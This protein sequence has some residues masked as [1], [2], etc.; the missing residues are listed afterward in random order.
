MAGPARVMFI[1]LFGAVGFLVL[2]ACANVA[3][4]LL[5]R[6]AHR[7]REMAVRVA[8]GATRLRIVR[9][10]LLESVVLGVPRRRVRR[11]HC[12]CRCAN[13]RRGRAGSREALLDHLQGRLLGARLRVG[14]V[15][16]DRHSVRPGARAARLERQPQQRAQRGRTRQCR[17]AARALA[18]RHDGRRRV[19]AD[20]RAAGRRRTDGSQLP[21]ALQPRHRH[22]H[23]SADGHAPSA[24]GDQI[25]E[26]RRSARVLRSARAAAARDCGRR[27]DCGHDGRA[28]VSVGAANVRDRRPAAARTTSRGSS[29]LRGHDQP[30]VLRCRAR[31]AAPRPGLQRDGRASRQRDRDH[32]RAAG[33]AVFSLERIRSDGASD[34]H[35]AATPLRASRAEMWRTIVGISPSIRHNEARD[36]QPTAAMYLPHRQ[37]PP[38]GRVA[39]GEKRAAAGVGDG[40]RAKGRAVGRSPISRSSP[41]RHSTRCSRSSRWPFRVFGSHLRDRGVCRARAVGRRVYTR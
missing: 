35:G 19:D 12:A 23:R 15:P 10:L 9:Q 31:S 39:A 22:S 28:A 30:A 29:V 33:V 26:S 37:E 17:R 3:N 13:G 41:S 8:M 7:A 32:Q 36:M 25:S 18:Q 38:G 6:S 5:S 34:S 14:D 4:L 21:V 1:T 27:G 20:D 16:G 40:R 2:I 11:A 24:A